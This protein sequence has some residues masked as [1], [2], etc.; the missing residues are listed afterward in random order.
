M[1]KVHNYKMVF[2]LVSFLAGV[3]KRF[4]GIIEMSDNRLLLSGSWGVGI[5]DVPAFRIK[6]TLWKERATAA[7]YLHDT[8][9]IG[10]LNGLY[11][12]TKDRTVTFLGKNI[13]FL[14]KRISAI[15]G[16]SGTQF[17]ADCFHKDDAG[18]SGDLRMTDNGL[19]HYKDSG[20]QSKAASRRNLLIH[21]NDIL[22]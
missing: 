5:F 7:Y 1:V 11:R 14:R 15:I 20:T 22:G 8:I 2:M 3:V 6:D 10:T 12:M 13:P 17:Y 21:I 19:N 18:I 4:L 9:Y 16:T